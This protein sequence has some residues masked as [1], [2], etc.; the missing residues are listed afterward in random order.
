MAD[1]KRRLTRTKL[2][3]A[4]AMAVLLIPMLRGLFFRQSKLAQEP[5]FPICSTAAASEGMDQPGLL[6][7]N[8][9][10]VGMNTQPAP[11]VRKEPVV[12][13]ITC[14]DK[15]NRFLQPGAGEDLEVTGDCQVT[16]Q[17]GGGTY[18]YRNVNIYT[19]PQSNIGGTLSFWDA[20]INFHA[21]S[22]LVENGG[23]L[24]AGSAT[25]DAPI[26]REGGRL[27]IYLYGK[28]Q[29]AGGLG[30]RCKSDPKTCG[31]PANIWNSNGNAKVP[32]GNGVEDYFYKYSPLPFDNGTD[33]QENAGYF[34][35]KVLA[36]SYG[37]TLQLFGKKGAVTLRKLKENDSGRSWGRLDGTILPGATKLKV[38]STVPLDWEKDDHIVVTTTDY[39][40]SHS[41]ELVIESFDGHD[42]IF[43]TAC[44]GAGTCASKGV[45]WTHNGV[46]YSLAEADH[47]GISRLKLNRTSAETRAAVALLTR[48]IR[49]VS[50][51]DKAMTPFP[52]PPT[53]YYF[54]GHTVARQGFKVFQ[55]QGVEFHQLGQ[56]GRLGPLPGPFPHGAASPPFRHPRASGHLRQRLFGQ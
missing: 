28:D 29:G 33:E 35:Y 22:I 6:L 31:V 34:G 13:I 54:G 47:N 48:S 39:L 55:M 12:P 4:S 43:H 15:G 36:V 40:A 21:Q 25:D 44:S 32:L 41:E 53:G 50:E 8:E 49:I 45:Q 14:P 26:G 16:G 11:V 56:G 37:G 51:G 42:I 24:I 52:P 18:W 23:S 7:R 5:V 17:V 19:K 1:S 3:I 10:G 27:T 38:D 20:V 9:P 2:L 30:I 46:R